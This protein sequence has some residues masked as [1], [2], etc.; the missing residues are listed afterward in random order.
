MATHK[1][2]KY[3]PLSEEEYEVRSESH[4]QSDTRADSN[5][6]G[7]VDETHLLGTL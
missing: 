7:F 4:P 3:F 5:H 1:G 6:E 2:Y